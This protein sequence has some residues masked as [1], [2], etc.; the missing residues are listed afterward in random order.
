MYASHWN[1]NPEVIKVLLSAGANPNTRCADG[2]TPLMAAVQKREISV[3]KYLLE[4]N[5]N[6]IDT[7]KLGHSVLEY[8]CK[9]SRYP[10]VIKELIPYYKDFEKAKIL[11]TK[12]KEKWAK[13]ILELLK[14]R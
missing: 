4:Y 11:L 10:E 13:E 12:R 8:A 7:D 1:A 2:W 6:P 3:I 9:Y 14:L 5:A